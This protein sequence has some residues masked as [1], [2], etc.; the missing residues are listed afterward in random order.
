MKINATDAEK[1][2]E[3]IAAAEGRATARTVYAEDVEIAIKSIE[4]KL[5]I[6]LLKKDWKGL[7][8]AV[9]TNAQNFASSYKYTPY[10]THF[11]LEKGAT[12]WFVTEIY[13][14]PCGRPTRE[15]IPMN[16]LTKTEELAQFVS[17]S[18]NWG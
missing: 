7:R 16:I 8:F 12:A 13:R 5:S 3:A 9:D 2:N 1:M 17:Q 14:A 15:I 4:K 10:S 18:K 6:L 11:V